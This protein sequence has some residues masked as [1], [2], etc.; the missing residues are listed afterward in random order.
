M[1][2]ILKLNWKNIFVC[3]NSHQHDGCRSRKYWR[4]VEY[5]WWYEKRDFEC[6]WL[7]ED[8]D[9][10]IDLLEQNLRNELG[11]NW[12]VCVLFI[13]KLKENKK[14]KLLGNSIRAGRK[15]NKRTIGRVGW[16]RVEIVIFFHI[17]MIIGKGRNRRQTDELNEMMKHFSHRL[18]IGREKGSRRTARLET[19]FLDIKRLRISAQQQHYTSWFRMFCLMVMLLEYRTQTVDRKESSHTKKGKL[20]IKCKVVYTKWRKF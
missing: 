3:K 20:T 1:I 6:N 11:L 2:L 18:G 16:G 12:T 14:K 17:I 15:K 4:F 9:E 10:D 5:E 13:T 8:M 19:A 7:D